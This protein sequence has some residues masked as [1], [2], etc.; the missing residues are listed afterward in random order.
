M[1]EKKL[2]EEIDYIVDC[3]KQNQ[4]IRK[5][6]TPLLEKSVAQMPEGNEQFRISFASQVLKK[7]DMSDMSNRTEIFAFSMLNGMFKSFWLQEMS[8]SEVKVT[9]GE[10][11]D[12]VG[13][14]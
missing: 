3:M 13:Q 11:L 14:N 6:C 2:Q 8:W 10:M 1:L 5:Y 7:P 12:R 9:I 4:D